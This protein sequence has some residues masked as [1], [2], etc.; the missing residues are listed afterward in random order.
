M[1]IIRLSIERPIAIVAMVLMIIL[2]GYVSLQRIPIQMAPDVRQ[3]VIIVK[4]SWPGA[5]PQEVEREVINPQEDELKGLEGVKKMTS[6]ALR[7][8]G[9]VTL[10]F[11]PEIN[12]DR[13]LLLVANRLAR[14]SGY[15]EEVDEPVLSTSG[16][17]DNAIAWFVIT[18]L[19][20]NTR[21]MTS[22]GD[23]LADV[24]QERIERV[25]G[26]AGVNIFGETKREMSITVTPESLA[27]YG[28]TVSEV[29]RRLR[30]AN[31]S[32]TGGEVGGRQTALCGAHGRRSQHSPAGRRSGAAERQRRGKS[33]CRGA[34][35]W[36]ILPKCPSVTRKRRRGSG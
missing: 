13:A 22:Y 3:P 11:G 36:V 26:V 23:F 19:D 12:F 32:I 2:F 21:D 28:M 15:P 5:A 8:R 6:R 24:L 30:A 33:R 18:R 9:A 27:R 7:N 16:T 17:E 25:K 14:V 29:L 34:S 31:A 20:G 35:W 1:N 4:T 10:E